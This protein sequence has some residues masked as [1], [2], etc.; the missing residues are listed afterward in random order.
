[1]GLKLLLENV[2]SIAAVVGPIFNYYPQYRIMDE[3]RSVGAFNKDVCYILIV[4]SML[5]IIFW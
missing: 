5:R 3:N 1:M 4:S 2:Y